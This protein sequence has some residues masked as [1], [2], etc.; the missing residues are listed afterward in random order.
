MARH[1]TYTIRSTA[2]YSPSKP[3][4]YTEPRGEKESHEDYEDRIWPL[5]AHTDPESGEV[6]IPAMSFKK[7]VETAATRLGIKVKGRGM[8]TYSK[9]V[10]SGLIPIDNANLGVQIGA[11]HCEAVLVSATGR[12]D[13]KGPRVIRKF[14]LFRDWKSEITFAVLD[15]NLPSEIVDRC[16][17]EAAALVGVGRFRPESG[18][19]FGRFEIVKT[20]W[21]NE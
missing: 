16:M 18:G 17:Q 4:Q 21:R 7:A 9:Y 10:R 20:V 12:A 14:P 15:D 13:G 19:Y 11:A 3:I 1:V 8:T 5:K 6:Y 2:P